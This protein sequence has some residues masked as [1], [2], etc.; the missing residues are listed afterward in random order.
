[1]GSKTLAKSNIKD[2]VQTMRRILEKVDKFVNAENSTEIH[3]CLAEIRGSS[4]RIEMALKD[5][6]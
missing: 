1:M 4:Q 3:T 2:A 5:L 6:R